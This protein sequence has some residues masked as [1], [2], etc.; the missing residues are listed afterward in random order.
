MRPFFQ[1]PIRLQRLPDQ[2]PGIFVLYP[3]GNRRVRLSIN[4]ASPLSVVTEGDHVAVCKGETIITRG[5]LESPL[6]H[7]PNRPTSP[8]ERCIFDCRFC[9]SPNCRRG[10]GYGYD[11]YYGEEGYA[12]ELLNAISLTSGVADTPDEEVVK[13][14]EVVSALRERFDLPIG[15]S[16]YPTASS[17][18]ILAA[19]GADEIK[20][21]VETMD[22]DIFT[23]VCPGLSLEFILDALEHA[24]EYSGKTRYFQI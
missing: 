20:Y 11:R 16:V 5:V 1:V 13:M 4:P 2:V 19:A 9:R 8:G 3:V 6:F 17:S 18:E 12:R 10:Q 15:V 22:P 14:A 21:N 23:Q 7:C 24:V